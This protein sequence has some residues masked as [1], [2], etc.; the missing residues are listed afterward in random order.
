MRRCLLAAIVLLAL[1]GSAAAQDWAKK[2]FEQTSHDFG[3]VARGANV[4]FRFA[5]ENPYVED[6][7]VESVHS[8][9]HCT[10]PEVVQPLVK[11]YE[12][13]EIIARLD[14]RKFYGRREATI[15]VK[16]DQPFP[17]EVQ[18]HVYS[19]IRSDVVLEP[20]TVQLGS[21]AQ[22]SPQ[23][24]KVSVS[25]AGRSDWEILDVESSRPFLSA[26]AVP[27]SRSGGQVM[28]DLWV[29]LAP[30]APAGYLRDQLMLVTN[31]HNPA[32]K[33][34]PVPVEGIVVPQLSA[35][36]SPLDFGTVRSGQS[37]TRNLIVQ[38]KAPFRITKIYSSDPRFSFSVSDAM[39]PV[40]RVPVTYTAGTDGKEM[41]GVIRVETDLGGGEAVDI[42]VTAQPAAADPVV[43]TNGETPAGSS[44]PA[45]EPAVR[46][47]ESDTPGESDESVGWRPLK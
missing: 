8:T 20:G 32:A 7:H 13:S 3:V 39:R 4:E 22:G 5:F 30:T 42:R 24:R 45:A 41:E 23:R 21:V 18:L 33:R 15:R 10:V 31:D 6:V 36:P 35:R 25:Y 26:K 19:Y 34:V 40:H 27:V 11:T 46:A 44:S 14:T 1:G 47:V 12:R 2:M 9:C 28:Y 37:V 38:G 29:E 16:F 43:P 17:A